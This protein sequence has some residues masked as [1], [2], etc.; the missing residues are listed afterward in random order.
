MPWSKIPIDKTENVK[1][2]RLRASGRRALTYREAIREA[3]S[4]AL[5]IDRRVFIMGEGVDDPGGIF[6]TTVGLK[7]KF[8]SKRVFDTP[9]AENT[10]TGV[11]IGAALAG[12]RP[13]FVHMRMDF[14]LP[15]MDQIVNH[16]SKWRFMFGGRVNVPIVIR[17]IIG[18]GWGSA[19]QHSQ[20]LQGLFVHTPGLKVVM[21]ATPYDAKGLLLG[22]IA[23]EDPVIFIEHRWLYDTVDHIPE[24]RYLIPLGKGM[25]RKKGRDVTVVATSHMVVEAIKAGKFLK[26]DGIDIEI[27]DPRTVAPLDEDLIIS[28]VKKTGRLIIADTGWKTGGVGAEISARVSEKAFKYLKAPILRISTADTPTPAG[29]SLEEAFYPGVADIVEAV[30]KTT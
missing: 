26:K 6:G 13:I 18:R 17:T 21:P 14:L 28:S 9:I 4:Q 23:D 29:P 30:K 25:V 16:A 5:A 10:M 15:A 19:A 12:T 7:G 11:A 1:A 3:L 24:D 27:I 22:S 20:S 2:A 8:G